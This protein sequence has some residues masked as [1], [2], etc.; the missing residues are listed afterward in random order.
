MNRTNISNRS[1]TVAIVVLVCLVV[2][3]SIMLG[4]VASSLRQRRQLQQ[5][6]QLEQTRLLLDAG[7]AKAICE[8]EKDA[9]YTGETLDEI[10]EI[11]NYKNVFLEIKKLE[12]ERVQFQVTA[13]LAQSK[14][15]GRT[16]LIQR[17]KTITLRKD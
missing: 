16:Q 8:F 17:S 1:G 12:S 10:D 15:A 2:T 6:I 4:A 11:G 14:E 9:G 7:I 3:S 5:E 13:K